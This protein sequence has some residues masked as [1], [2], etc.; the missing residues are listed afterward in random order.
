MLKNLLILSIFLLCGWPLWAAGTIEEYPP[1]GDLNGPRLAQVK[2]E[3]L[4]AEVKGPWRSLH[5]RYRDVWR[6]Q[7]RTFLWSAQS[8]TNPDGSLAYAVV[9]GE[10]RSKGTLSYVLAGG[11][12][13]VFVEGLGEEDRDDRYRV[14]YSGLQRYLKE[15]D[16]EGRLKP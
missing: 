11:S 8:Y 7:K 4:Q 9:L 15:H 6:G 2:A 1:G 10:A 12:A 13:S 5:L 14:V 3:C 16:A